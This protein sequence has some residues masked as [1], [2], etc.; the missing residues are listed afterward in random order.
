M[1]N[2]DSYL[3][4]PGFGV[5]AIP[6][7]SSAISSAAPASGGDWFAGLLGGL[8]SLANT[9]ANTYRNVTG[10]IKG[11][12]TSTTASTVA[13]TATKYLPWI[14]IGVAVLALGFFFVM[15]RKGR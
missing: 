9:A 8:N 14:V 15:L 6:T 10:A 1:D 11:T 5:T 4:N 12:P 13:A 2:F 3:V 7:I